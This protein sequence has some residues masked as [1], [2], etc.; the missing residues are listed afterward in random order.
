VSV[1]LPVFG[2]F[3]TNPDCSFSWSLNVT[4]I[5]TAPIQIRGVFFEGGKEF[6]SLAIESGIDSSFAQGM[7]IRQ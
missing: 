1:E 5:T 3:T 6:Y 2:T 7:R 4:G